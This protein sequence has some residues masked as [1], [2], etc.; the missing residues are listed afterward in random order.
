MVNHDDKA[1][2]K[3]EHFSE[4]F[5]KNANHHCYAMFESVGASNLNRGF[6]KD[7]I[8]FELNIKNLDVNL[9]E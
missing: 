8:D 4:V 7:A 5:E 2:S 3:T 9:V 6:V 1:K